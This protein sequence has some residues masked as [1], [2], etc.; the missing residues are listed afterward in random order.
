MKTAKLIKDNLTGFV[1]HAALYELTPAMVNEKKKHKYVI[2]SSADAM[3]TGIETF[4]FPANKEGNVIDWGEL[5]GSQRGTSSHS[6]V[7]SDAGYELI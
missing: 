4:I 5:D 3:F 2:C 1:G 6:E 7:L